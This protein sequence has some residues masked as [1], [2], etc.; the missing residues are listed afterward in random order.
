MTTAHH[1]VPTH[2]GIHH[3]LEWMWIS[4]S[5]VLVALV[6]GGIAW[7]VFQ[8]AATIAPL[9]DQVVGFEYSPEA[10]VGR[11]GQPGVTGDYFG[12]SGA[13]HPEVGVAQITD[14]GEAASLMRSV[15]ASIAAS[16]W[17]TVGGFELNHEATTGQIAS[18]GVNGE[19]FG[20]SGEINPDR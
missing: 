10:T 7:V 1:P 15:D 18:P 14:P 17:A 6:A 19:Y 13:L 9:P 4:L 2:A 8:P 16:H 20:Y 5:V 3:N 12:Y 11:V